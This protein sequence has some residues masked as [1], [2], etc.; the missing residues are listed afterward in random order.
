MKKLQVLSI[1]DGF[2]KLEDENG[3]LYSF[4]FEFQGIKDI[5]LIEYIYISEELLNNSY[6]EY[7]DFYTFGTLDSE[8]GRNIKENETDV[9][10]VLI[11]GDVI[12]LK[13][14]YG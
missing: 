3:K 5:N 12:Y 9:I 2:Y 13:R 1:N 6:E 14:L 10:G 4:H 11:N 8:Y 7:S